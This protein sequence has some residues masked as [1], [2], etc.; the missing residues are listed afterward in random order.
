MTAAASRDES[1]AAWRRFLEA[2]GEHGSAF[3]V[4]EDL[5]WADDGLL[6]FVDH[7]VDWA[8]SV[9]LV[10]V[11]TARPELLSR[12]PGW[13]GGKA[14][15][16]TISLAPLSDA[17][18]ARLVAGLVDRAV[19][20]A[21]VQAALLARAGGNPLYAEEFV[22]MTA[23]RGSNLA[24][25]VLPETVQG[26]IA[27]RLDALDPEAKT[28]LQDAAVLGKVFWLGGVTAIGGRE[29]W[30]AE[31]QLHELERREL[32]RRERRSSV[33]GEVEFAFWHALVRDVA[34]GQIPRADRADRDRAAAEW[35]AS[36]AADR[37][38]DRAD[39]LAHH[40][41][42]ALELARAAG[43]DTAELEEPARLALR[44]AGERALAL[45]SYAAAI[46]FFDQALALWPADDPDRAH[47][48]F[49]RPRAP[50]GRRRRP[51][52]A[53]RGT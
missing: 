2:L 7:L 37:V 28:L 11:C 1:F 51:R 48:L 26:I 44:M 36:L 39:L 25:A 27:A 42:A 19:M 31:R 43:R 38:A 18:T 9:P 10:V 13:G 50:R 20:P 16:T 46:R 53:H 35:I 4:F 23:E 17:D 21:E 41:L 32:V 30:D 8:S 45:S 40:Y 24:D 33:G 12:R 6:D 22:R 14:N 47:V 49:A 29:R 52:R 15:A 5:H 34:Y 3:L